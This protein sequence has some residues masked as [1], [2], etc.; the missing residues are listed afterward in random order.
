MPAIEDY[1]RRQLVPRWR[2]S[3]ETARR[4]ELTALGSPIESHFSAD[5]V[6]DR[7]HDWKQAPSLL[8]ASDL[9]GA[10]YALGLEELAVDAA[11]F[12]LSRRQEAQ[13]LA[14][15]IA[16]L[17]LRSAGIAVELDENEE[18]FAVESLTEY[19]SLDTSTKLTAADIHRTRIRLIEF[20]QNPLLWADL[21]LLYTTV[22][23]ATKAERAMTV[24]LSMARHN[25][26]VVRSASRLFL[27]QGDKEKAHTL[28]EKTDGILTDPWLVSAEIALASARRKTS[29]NMRTAR[30][31]LDAESYR[32]LHLSELASSMGTMEA[33]AGNRRGAQKLIAKS[34]R[35]PTENSV[36]QATWLVR[37][38][39]VS[40]AFHLN[41]ASS[42]E[43]KARSAWIAGDWHTAVQEADNWLVDQ[44][45]SIRP[46]SLGANITG[47]ILGDYAAAAKRLEEGRRANPL[48]FE[49]LND[50]TF[51]LAMDG[52]IE[53]AIKTYYKISGSGL[54]EPQKVVYIATGGLLAFRTG[55]EELGMALYRNAIQRSVPLK[56]GRKSF[57]QVYLAFEMLRCGIPGAEAARAKALE[58]KTLAHNLWYQVILERLRAFP[59][60][61]RAE[62]S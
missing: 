19:A 60:N 35:E 20:P 45:F 7:I 8:V 44:R 46:T 62:N 40:Q 10:A 37:Q 16:T 55:R 3:N 36:A 29:R 59:T 53:D 48:S 61:E 58:D 39:H 9:V 42:A 2:Q 34:L 33:M 50:L 13:P 31:L 57:A 43:A 52:R 4:G 5:L 21:S 11:Q 56:D 15:K 54:D 47:S 41:L 1:T 12:I 23:E 38:H 17:T 14:C 22:G 6:A 18:P 27:H 26:H 25:R 49:I 28:L 51:M 30:K 32:P 24:A